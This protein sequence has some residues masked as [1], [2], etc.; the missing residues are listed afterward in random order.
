[1]MKL[2]DEIINYIDDNLY[3]VSANDILDSFPVSRSTLYRSFSLTTGMSLSTY[4]RLK[5]LLLSIHELKYTDHSIL[6]ISIKTGY[7]SQEAFTRS[8]KKHFGFNPN[9]LRNN[10]SSFKLPDIYHD[11]LHQSAHKAIEL[12]FTTELYV[13]VSVVYKPT[14]KWVAFIDYN[15]DEKFYDKCIELGMMDVIDNL[16]GDGRNGGGFRVEDDKSV[17]AFYGKEVDYETDFVCPEKCEVLYIPDSYYLVF[18][19]VYQPEDHGSAVK[20]TY[21]AMNNFDPNPIGYSWLD[22]LP[23]YNDDDEHGFTLM[24]AIKRK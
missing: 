12:G 6:D 8:L 21:D 7:S 16:P 13:K 9:E 11:M 14:H 18:N 23:I 10:Q 24:K 5:R 20:S 19:C 15:P 17:I 1:M 3:K 2:I 4:I 22:G